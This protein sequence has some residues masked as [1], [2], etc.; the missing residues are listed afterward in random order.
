MFLRR[1]IVSALL[2]TGGATNAS[3]AAAASL[4]GSEGDVRSRPHFGDGGGCNKAWSQYVAA[5]G[6]SAYATTPYD[7]MAEAIICG[8]SINAGSKAAA[9]TNALAQCNA[10]L[11]RWKMSVVRKC[12][13]SASK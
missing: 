6:H 10:G 9:E 3:F 7:R 11:K 12:G 1:L 13:I 2:V 5:S 4:A 8:S